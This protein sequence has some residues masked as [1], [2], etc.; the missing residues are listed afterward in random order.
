MENDVSDVSIPQLNNAIQLTN[1]QQSNS[2]E[3]LTTMNYEQTKQWLDNLNIDK[4]ILTELQNKVQNGQDLLSIYTNE[5]ILDSL[6]LDFHNKNILITS[7]EESLENQLKINI[8]LL[9]NKKI[10]FILENDL[11]YE[12]KDLQNYLQTILNYPI[13]LTPIN[14]QNEI[15]LPNT[16]IVKKILLNPKKYCNLQILD[17]KMYSNNTTE[18]I[19]ANEKNKETSTIEML[20]NFSYRNKTND[21]KSNTINTQKEKDNYSMITKKL[22]EEKNTE[23]NSDYKNFNIINR[24]S[25]PKINNLK[26]NI[27]ADEL[28]YQNILT[29]KPEFGLPNN[30]NSQEENP[31]NN[32]N[33]QKKNSGNQL[34]ENRYEFSHIHDSLYSNKI[35]YNIPKNSNVTPKYNFDGNALNQNNKKENE[36]SDNDILKLLREK[37]SLGNNNNNNISNISNINNNTNNNDYKEPD[38]DSVNNINFK[39]EYKAKT[40]IS[41]GRR[42]INTDKINFAPSNNFQSD[43]FALKKEPTQPFMKYN[44]IGKNNDSNR[45]GFGEEGNSN[46]VMAQFQMD[47]NIGGDM[48]NNKMMGNLG[49]NKGQ[50][51]DFKAFQYKSSGYKSNFGSNQ[52]SK[53]QRNDFSKFSMDNT[54]S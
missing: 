11:K 35:A 14:N 21:T 43:L 1:P 52:N 9:N 7:I 25:N 42:T 51:L 27:T 13:Y 44:T 24:N 50:G 29:K 10:S 36:G 30:E 34:P 12:L 3:Y 40:P 15:L 45:Q 53:I 39:K 54:D 32:N 16:L 6:N 38:N 8:K 49:M 33:L 17:I 20:P 31:I 28:M 37:Y 2:Q 5:K 26:T 22:N 19:P 23:Q 41:E 48:M 18:N 46:A 4:S 47:S